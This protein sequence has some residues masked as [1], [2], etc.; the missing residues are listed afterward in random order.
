MALLLLSVMAIASAP[1][2]EAQSL[3][4]KLA[5]QGTLAS[6]LPMMKA[7]QTEELLKEEKTL[8]EEERTKLGQQPIVCSKRDTSAL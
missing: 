6:L 3:G 7:S 4:R 5:S 1:S 2:A 8:S